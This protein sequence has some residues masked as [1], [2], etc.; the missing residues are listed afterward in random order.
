VG[1]GAAGLA[2]DVF[3][4]E[5]TFLAVRVDTDPIDDLIA[6]SNQFGFFD[7]ILTKHGLLLRIIVDL[8]F[9]LHL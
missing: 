2:L 6:L 9:H 3:A 8:H 4:D 7:V 1:L 5:G